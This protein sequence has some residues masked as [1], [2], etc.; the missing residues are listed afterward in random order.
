MRLL[1]YTAAGLLVISLSGCDRIP[2]LNRGGDDADQATPA[3]TDSAPAQPVVRDTAPEPPIGPKSD[4]EIDMPAEVQDPETP[5]QSRAQAL[6][7]EPWT[8]TF[9]GTVNP[10]MTREDVVATWGPP[11]TERASGAWTYLYYRNG[12][13]ITCGTHDIVLL[14]GGQV[15]DAVV[16]GPGHNYSGMS[17]SPPGRTAVFTPPT[18]G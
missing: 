13:E 7:D 8:P 18:Q 12:C 14:Q 1:N 6:V 15:V 2:F 11:I 9:T 10:G 16:R 4:E 5:R 17:S 3:A